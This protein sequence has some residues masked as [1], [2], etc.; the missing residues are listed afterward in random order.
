MAR[1]KV[2]SKHWELFLNFAEQHPQIL[3]G[4]FKSLNAKQEDQKLWQTIATQL[5]ALGLGE[6]TA[7]KWKESVIDW[8]CKTKKKA[9]ELRIHR[10]KTGGG[11]VSTKKLSEI[12]ERLL[13]IIGITA[14][15]GDIGL[16]EVGLPSSNEEPINITT[17]NIEYV[18]DE[19]IDDP[20]VVH[21]ESIVTSTP[22]IPT[23]TSAPIIPT[24]TSVPVIPT[25]MSASVTPTATS[26]VPIIPATL[27]TSNATPQRKRKRNQMPNLQLRT[28]LMQKYQNETLE[29]MDSIVTSLNQNTEALISIKD[30]ISKS[31]KEN[32]QT[33]LLIRDALVNITNS[34][35]NAN[36]PKSSYSDS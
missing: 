3:T 31:T 19:L 7:I 23:I 35:C 24:I 11:G 33:V 34:F 21:D 8:K 26:A 4:K 1:M 9:S 13:S 5:N 29:K 16:E 30:A 20:A 25:V 28:D 32:S 12:E 15:E 2:Q 17:A 27:T 14:I 18:Y 36:V 10:G 6:K 22:V